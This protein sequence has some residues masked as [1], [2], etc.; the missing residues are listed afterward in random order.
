MTQCD[1][2]VT[3]TE[4][5]TCD[6]VPRD[7]YLIVQ[8]ENA[9]CKVKVSDLVLGTE[10]IDFYPELT[11][12]LNRLD[13]LETLVATNSGNW[14]TGYGH[15]ISG[16]DVW[17]QI[18]DLDLQGMKDTLDDNKDKWNSVSDTVTDN[19]GSWNNTAN[20]I[21]IKSDN[22]DSA[23]DIVST[24]KQDWDTAY[25]ATT[26]GFQAIAEAM[27]MVETSP[28]FTLYTGGSAQSVYTTVNQ[29]SGSWS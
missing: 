1:K 16:K 18:P 2:T 10:N 12:I 11:E 4:L 20:Q 23:Y 14:T 24:S 21:E 29:N 27:E 9:T 13:L 5:P 22:W 25:V 15:A 7:S 17:N 8:G 6:N 28:W 26:D 3:L 19:A